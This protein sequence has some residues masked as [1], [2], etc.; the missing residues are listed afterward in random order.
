MDFTPLLFKFILCPKAPILSI[1]IRFL[2]LPNILVVMPLTESES[3][4]DKWVKID[5]EH[6]CVCL[7]H[8]KKYKETK[9]ISEVLIWKI[10]LEFSEPHVLI[11]HE[12]DV[13]AENYALSPELSCDKYCL[14]L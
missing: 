10:A 3:G 14:D 8:W 1:F 6:Y 7:D 13:G 4:S 2:H 5:P 9:L 12:F 11:V